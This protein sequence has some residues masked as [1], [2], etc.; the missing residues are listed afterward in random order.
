VSGEGDPSRPSREVG[1]PLVFVTVGTD[2]HPFGRLVGWIDAWLEGRR[3]AKLRCVVQHGA[4]SP[5][6]HAEG[7]EIMP[8]EDILD[9]TSR[10]AAVVCQAGPASV[11]LTRGTGRK[12]IVVPRTKRHGEHVDDHQVAFAERLEREGHAVVAWSEGDLSAILERTL[13]EPDWLVVDID[14]S[15]A[16]AG[17][18]E[19]FAEI[20]DELIGARSGRPPADAGT[21]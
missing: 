16:V 14:R 20:A 2:H 17:T 3:G 9:L 1:P 4:T 10:A 19:R 5:P 18:V 11:A 6:R 13:A 21:G 15:D 12:P 7:V 8:F